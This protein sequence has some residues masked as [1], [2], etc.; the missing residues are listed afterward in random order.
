MNI[1]Y[2]RIFVRY[3]LLR[4]PEVKRPVVTAK[5]PALQKVI[6]CVVEGDDEG[7]ATAVNEALKS[8]EPLTVINEGLVKGMNEVSRLWDDGTYYLPQVLLASDAMMKGIELCEEKMGKAAEKKGVVVTHTAEGDIHDL[9]QQI[10]NALLRA[11]GYEVID[12]GKDVPID[13]V[14]AAVKRHKPAMVTGTALMT[15]TMTAFERISNRLTNEG[16]EIPFVCGGGAVSEEY[17]TSF[18]LGVYGKDASWAPGLASD[19]VAGKGWQ[20][21]RAKWNG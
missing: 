21:I 20:D 12:L 13:D 18:K 11:N 19:A 14:V 16:V 17:V 6:D 3:D 9:G 4:E 10:V 7:I 2:D 8:V 15:T 1:S 5:V